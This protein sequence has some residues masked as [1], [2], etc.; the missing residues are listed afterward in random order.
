MPSQSLPSSAKPAIA[1]RVFGRALE[2]E[3]L[4]ASE[5]KEGFKAALLKQAAA[6]R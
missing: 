6:Y 1:Y 5:Q 4:A 3:R 2:F